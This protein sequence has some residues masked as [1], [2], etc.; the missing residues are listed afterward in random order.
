MSITTLPEIKIT[1]KAFQAQ[2]RHLAQTLGYLVY[3]TWR[4]T[5]SPAGFPDLVMCSPTQCRVVYAELKAE[6]G[7]LSAKQQGWLDTLRAAGQEVYL[8]RP[9]DWDRIIEILKGDAGSKRLSI[10]DKKE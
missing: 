7:R 6:S 1:E 4:S 5:H 3:F 2:V 8:W 9:S 10:A